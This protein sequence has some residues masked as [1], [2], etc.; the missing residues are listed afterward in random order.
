MTNSHPIWASTSAEP[1]PSAPIRGALPDNPV[2]VAIV[3]G[4]YTGLSTALHAAEAGLSVQLFEA[5]DVGHGGSGRNVGLVNAAAWLPPAQL[6]ARLGDAAGA[7]FLSRFADAPNAVF[8]LIERHQIR[9]EATRNGTIHAATS[10]S[11]VADLRARH[12]EWARL[13]APV[14][15][16]DATEMQARTGSARFAAGLLDA[17]AGTLQ[18]MAYCRGLAR[19]AAAAG[20]A[21]A[22]HTPVTGLTRAGSHWRLTSAAGPVLARSVVLATNAYAGPL[23]PGLDKS[24]LAMRYFQIA[25][26]PLGDRAARVLPEGQGLWTNARVM[27][28]LRRDREG[29]LVL[30]GMGPAGAPDAARAWAG[31][32]LDRLYPDIGPVS[33][34]APWDGKIALTP[35][36]IPR[37]CQIADGLYAPIGYNGRGIT[38]GTVFGQ[39]IAGLLT[40]DDP[41]ALPLP[42][43]TQPRR[44][45]LPGLQSRLLNSGLALAQRFALR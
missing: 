26:E 21:L 44:L 41:D 5:Q 32:L 14:T 30:G 35:D 40:G 6:R 11:G 4:G 45:V 22:T 37:I 16:L 42:L 43:S 29:R 9:C 13:G 19:A 27:V 24:F 33:W 15:L 31:R 8:A 7:R 18:P 34:S 2:D 39:S 28:S 38:T 12:A 10:A 20:A 3:G 23:W 25:S 36:H 1:D 17:R